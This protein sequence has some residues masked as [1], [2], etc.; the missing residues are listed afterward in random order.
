MFNRA[1]RVLDALLE[2]KTRYKMQTYDSDVLYIATIALQLILLSV[3]G[4]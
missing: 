4:N 1:P 2:L 3:I